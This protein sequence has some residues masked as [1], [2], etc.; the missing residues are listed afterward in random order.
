[1]YEELVA[2]GGVDFTW[3]ALD[4]RSGST[5]CYT[6]GTTGDPKGVVYSH[7]GTVLNAM[8][9][10]SGSAWAAGPADSILSVAQF[11]H[12]NGWGAPYVGPMTGAK[13]VLPGRSL[14]S[15]SLRELIVN[16]EVTIAT[17]VPTIWLSMM[18]HLSAAGGGLGRLN[19]IV[20]GG[21]APPPALIERLRR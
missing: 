17:G 3:P 20:C 13:L 7:R 14:D 6:S 1:C 16:E 9:I 15:A 4:E 19:R 2:G 5:L 12:C 18:E 21:T 8:A 11:F 10:A